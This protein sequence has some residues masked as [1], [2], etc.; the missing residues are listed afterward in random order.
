MQQAARSF[1]ELAENLD[2]RSAG[3][4]ADGRRT[5][6]DID[7]AVNNFD[8]KSEPRDL[9]WCGLGAAA[10]S[11]RRRTRPGPLS[12]SREMTALMD[13]R[14]IADIG[15]TNARFAI[16]RNG[17]YDRLIHVEVARYKVLARRAAGLPQ[18]PAACDVAVAGRN[19]GGRPG[20]RRPHCAHHIYRGPSPSPN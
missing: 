11:A 9:R 16:A 5:L 1:R 14:L 18:R 3:L 4:I 10:I 6:A 15:G 17:T 7:R 8:R 20:A 2:K 13:L 12:L 19:R